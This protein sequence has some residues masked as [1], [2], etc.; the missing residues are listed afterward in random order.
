M[1][2]SFL[3]FSKAIKSSNRGAGGCVYLLI[4][5]ILTTERNHIA[6][7]RVHSRA[8]SVY[9]SCE[10]RNVALEETLI[11]FWCKYFVPSLFI[12]GIVI[13][14]RRHYIA[15]IVSSHQRCIN[16]RITIIKAPGTQ[17]IR[18]LSVLNILAI[19]GT[20]GSSGFGSHKREQMDNNTE[21]IKRKR[22]F[23]V[24]IFL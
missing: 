23:Y 4:G 3:R 5:E 14:T 15:F 24:S 20:S 6:Y 17:Q 13:S 2:V 18:T 8:N 11:L 10:I 22:L 19:S 21:M 12:S 9:L 16:N 1:W 7:F